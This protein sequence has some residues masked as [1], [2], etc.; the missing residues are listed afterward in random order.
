MTLRHLVD[1]DDPKGEFKC[2]CILL[3]S[4]TNYNQL[5]FKKRMRADEGVVFFIWLNRGIQ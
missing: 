3:A 2:A 4:M 5:V 1:N